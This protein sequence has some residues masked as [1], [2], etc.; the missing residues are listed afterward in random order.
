MDLTEA[1]KRQGDWR[2]GEH[3]R[4]RGEPTGERR[5]K[6]L[7]PWR[8]KGVMMIPWLEGEIKT[9]LERWVNRAW[10]KEGK[11][12]RD[13]GEPLGRRRGKPLIEKGVNP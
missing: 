4:K 13:G 1:P 7:N 5:A 9:L 2:Q 6:V 11:P 3:E 8:K 10:E 12:R